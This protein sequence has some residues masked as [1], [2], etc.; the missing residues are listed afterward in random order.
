MNAKI[1][2]VVELK[3]IV[4]QKRGEY[5]SSHKGLFNIFL[6]ILIMLLG[7][8]IYNTVTENKTVSKAVVKPVSIVPLKQKRTVNFSCQDKVYCYV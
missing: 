4:R 5:T 6:F 3:P 8:Y 2:G 7:F 1:E